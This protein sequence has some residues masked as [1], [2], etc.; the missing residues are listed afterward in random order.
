MTTE[1]IIFKMRYWSLVTGGECDPRQTADDR[2]E[3]DVAAEGESA[4]RMDCS[5]QKRPGR[6]I[7]QKG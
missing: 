5:S 4:S 2:P 1:K 6:L 3:Q 7:S